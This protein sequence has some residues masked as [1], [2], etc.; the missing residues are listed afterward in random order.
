MVLHVRNS[1]RFWP[2]KTNPFV[3]MA[4]S[5]LSAKSILNGLSRI[6]IN[7]VSMIAEL[8][9]HWEVLAEAI[10]TILRKSGQEDAYEKLKELTQGQKIDSIVMK[11]FVSKLS[12]SEKDKRT[13]LSL[14]P[15]QYT[16][17]ASKVVEML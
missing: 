3:C 11:Q 12:I 7:K 17:N 13:L 4:H 5:F 2:P 6:T 10:Q 8:D 9:S 15:D 16:G 14:T 1:L